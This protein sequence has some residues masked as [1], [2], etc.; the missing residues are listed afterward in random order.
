VLQEVV[1]L[2]TVID[3]HIKLIFF[4]A[5]FKRKIFHRVPLVRSE[6]KIDEDCETASSLV[7]RAVMMLQID[8]GIRSQQNEMTV[9][10][11]QVHSIK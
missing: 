6:S 3:K 8:Q 11:S 5:V 10:T 9:Y 4:V 7:K 1:D 2:E